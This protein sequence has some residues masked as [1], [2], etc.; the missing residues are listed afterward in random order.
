MAKSSVRT[1]FTSPT[2]GRPAGPFVI[3]VGK[4]SPDI[5]EGEVTVSKTEET[6][7][8]QKASRSVVV[9]PASEVFAGTVT[10][11]SCVRALEKSI[12]FT[13]GAL[14]L[15]VGVALAVFASSSTGNDLS[16]RRRVMDIYEQA[17]F[18]VKDRGPD[19]KTCHRRMSA[20]AALFDKLGKDAVVEA[21]RGLRDGKAIDS[22]CMHLGQEYKFDSINAVLEFVGKPVLQTNTAE[23]RAARAAKVA[24]ELNNETHSLTVGERMEARMAE[25][26]K[27]IAEDSDGII[28]SAG[29]L[30]IVVPRDVTPDEVMAMVAKL[31]DF[32][33]R[34]KAEIGTPED[35]RN[36]EMH[37]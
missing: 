33:D 3:K 13:K 17:G 2:A 24:A 14:Y 15:E 10:A 30:S 9:K 6:G 23:V 22:L 1:K 12:G 18:D 20:S 34:L 26:Q 8:N 37:S 7:P 36:R 32:A 35:Q 28:V 4:K 19:Y 25:R 29:K 27:Q 11:D 5:L 31:T 21:M 16:T